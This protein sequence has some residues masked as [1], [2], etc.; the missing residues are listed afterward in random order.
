[1]SADAK[2][3]V[4]EDSVLLPALTAVISSEGVN[5]DYEPILATR[6]PLAD[7][8]SEELLTLL[9]STFRKRGGPGLVLVDRN[10]P[11]QRAAIGGRYAMNVLYEVIGDEVYA[12]PGCMYWM[13]FNNKL[14][15]F[16]HRYDDNIARHRVEDITK[17]HVLN[18]ILT[19]L[20]FY[21]LYAYKPTPFPGY[22]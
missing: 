13:A 3:A 6:R 12:S 18:R 15:A 4:F 9:I 14:H 17:E 2:I 8:Q 10:P 16:A 7:A 20:S 19:S 22:R 1:M 11:A 21:K 5:R